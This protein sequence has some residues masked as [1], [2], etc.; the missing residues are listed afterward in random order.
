MLY[1]FLE[2]L[3]N[4]DSFILLHKLSIGDS[5]L[6]CSLDLT[7]YWGGEE[8]ISQSF[9]I[10]SK[11]ITDLLFVNEFVFFSSSSSSSA[12]ILGEYVSFGTNACLIL[13]K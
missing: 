2:H 1:V 12:S 13:L 8:V 7:P 9:I 10:Y 5:V 3:I 6:M 11:L 4:F